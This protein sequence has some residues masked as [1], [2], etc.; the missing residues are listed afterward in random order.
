MSDG[1]VAN[2]EQALSDINQQIVDKSEILKHL[3]DNLS[4]LQM[5]V[6]ADSAGIDIAPVTRKLRDLSKGM[7]VSL[8]TASA[9]SFPLSR[10]GMGTRSLAALLVFRAFASWRHAHANKGGDKVHSLLALEEPRL[11]DPPAPVPVLA[12]GAS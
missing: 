4:N 11:V 6:S 3:K 2:L 10:H 1:D 9:Q 5:I 7:D 8:T 12:T